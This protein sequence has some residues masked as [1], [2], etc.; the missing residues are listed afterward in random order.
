[1]AGKRIVK[2]QS[3]FRWPENA[4]SNCKVISG[5]RTAHCQTAK[6][7]P[8]AGRRI[9]KLQSHFR[10]PENALSNCKVISGGRKTHCQ[11]AKSFPVA[12]NR[13]VKLQ[14]HFRWPDGALQFDNAS[15]KPQNGVSEKFSAS[16]AMQIR[17]GVATDGPNRQRKMALGGAF[18]KFLYC[19]EL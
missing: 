1:V 2:L 19:W 15:Q 5:G 14:S 13:I 7:F 8:V 11:T 16:S 4:L 3:H 17:W 18:P 12:G 10:W 9:V 6:P